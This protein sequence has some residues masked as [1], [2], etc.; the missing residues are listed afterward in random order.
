MEGCGGMCG[1]VLHLEV[2]LRGLERFY[3]DHAAS[4][5]HV[6]VHVIRGTS[7]RW[8]GLD[9]EEQCGDDC[10]V[11]HAWLGMEGGSYRTHHTNTYNIYL[12]ITSLKKFRQI[13]WSFPIC[14]KG[15]GRIIKLPTYILPHYDK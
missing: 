2:E 7:L 4:L 10:H 5:L 8:C 11:S 13:R 1:V 3:R 9:D 12:Y 6:R 15:A 14:T